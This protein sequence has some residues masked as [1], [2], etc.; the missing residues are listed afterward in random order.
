MWDKGI[1]KEG[2][3]R[4]MACGERVE[5]S[6]VGTI[7]CPLWERRCGLGPHRPNRGPQGQHF[8]DSDATLLLLPTSFFSNLV[9]FM[10]VFTCKRC[11][12]INFTVTNLSLI[13]FVFSFKCAEHMN[14][15]YGCFPPCICKGCQEI[16]DVLSCQRDFH[17]G[18]SQ[19]FHFQTS[20]VNWLP[21][22]HCFDLYII[23]S[24]PCP[25][26]L[27]KQQKLQCSKLFVTT[28]YELVN[29]LAS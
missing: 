17:W 28:A 6:V 10:R 12:K 22:Y 14:L 1:G 24:L 4:I 15:K 8:K 27:G 26:V 9:I 11:K 3:E 19:G 21:H 23:L 2:E 25:F 13:R 5:V 16:I 18:A 29:L 20:S 7:W